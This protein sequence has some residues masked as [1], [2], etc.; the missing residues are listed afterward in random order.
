VFINNAQ[1]VMADITADNGVVHVIDAVLTPSTSVSEV[2]LNE[3]VVYPN[4]AS[5]Q[6]TIS[7]PVV[8]SS[9]TYMIYSATGTLVSTGSLYNVNTT[10]QV[11]ALA[12]GVYQLKLVNGTECVTRT[13]MKK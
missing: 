8:S 3:S 6:I 12:Q 4:P 9:S 11:D 10:L 7:M 13:F 5:D 1:V 2:A